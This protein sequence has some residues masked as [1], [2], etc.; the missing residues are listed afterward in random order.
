[1]CAYQL[2]DKLMLWIM[3][4]LYFLAAEHVVFLGDPVLPIVFNK[5]IFFVKSWKAILMIH[6]LY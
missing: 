6:K 1:M 4:S 2:I 3:F 5:D